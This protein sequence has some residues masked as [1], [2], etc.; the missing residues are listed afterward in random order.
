MRNLP[1]ATTNYTVIQRGNFFKPSQMWQIIDITKQLKKKVLLSE[2][3][4]RINAVRPE[5]QSFKSQ[6]AYIWP[7]HG[8]ENFGLIYNDYAGIINQKISLKGSNLTCL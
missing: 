4:M 2:P 6:P 3:Y 8:Y 7:A 1:S 5:Q